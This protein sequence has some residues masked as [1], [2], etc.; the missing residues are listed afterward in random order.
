MVPCVRYANARA[1]IHAGTRHT[2]TRLAPLTNVKG[3][4]DGENMRERSKGAGAGV[5]VEKEE[6]GKRSRKGSNGGE[7]CDGGEGWE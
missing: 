7:E 4:G 1:E 2:A 3:E 5:G 6:K